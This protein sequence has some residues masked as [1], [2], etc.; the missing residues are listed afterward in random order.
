MRRR[1]QSYTDSPARRA[2]TWRCGRPASAAAQIVFARLA[3]RRDIDAPDAPVDVSV[4][5]FKRYFLG[6][7]DQRSRLGSLRAEPV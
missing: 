1:L 4:P 5:F 7:S 3:A 2:P 6:G